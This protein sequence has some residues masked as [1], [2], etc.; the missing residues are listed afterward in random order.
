MPGRRYSDG[1]HQALEAK[2]SVTVERETQTFATVTIQNFFR[3][4]EKL[5]GMTGT[6]ETEAAEFLD[7]Y[8]LDV[9][10]VPTNEPVRRVD[11]DDVIYL[12]KREKYN[13]IIDEIIRMHE[14]GRPVLVGTVSV[15]VSE[16]LS[17][18][19]KRKGINHS[20]LNAKY[21]EQEARIVARAGE[22]G[23]VTI[24][25]NM[26]GRGTDIKLGEGVVTCDRCCYECVEGNCSECPKA[27]NT[28]DKCFDDMPCGLHIIGTE[29]HE[30]RRIDRQLRGRSGRQGDP[31][32][33]RFYL[34]LEDDLMRLFGSDRLAGVISRLG[35]QDGE[36]I[37]HSLIT[38]Q[39]ERAQKRVEANNFA[40]RKHLLEYDDVM[41]KQREV[42]YSKRLMALESEDISPEIREMVDGVV[43]RKL[44]ACAPEGLHPEEWDVTNLVR[45]VETLFRW[46]FD[47]G[48]TSDPRTSSDDLRRK[49]QHAALEAY[50]AKQREIG[51][52]GIK[53]IER[54]LLLYVIDKHW[55]D[56]LYD[57]DGVRAGI[58]LRAYGQKDPLIEYKAEAFELFL[59]ML[60][61]IE[62]E[63]VTLLFQGRWVKQEP[64][65]RVATPRT[66][67]FKPDVTKPEPAPVADPAAVAAPGDRGRQPARTR[68]SQPR[69][70][71]VAGVKVGRNDPCPC[72][73]GKKYKKC[74][75]R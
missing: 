30:S 43:G 64:E 39:I 20:V 22:A 55:R 37:Q 12:T 21:H 28:A 47:L 10:V 34:S 59:K 70:P 51:Y 24:A 72:G 58:G 7:I 9:T 29:R 56:H 6:A 67:A 45:E 3:L 40:I 75:G 33:S 25:T 41:N 1:L 15:E 35:I 4:Y 48:D 13:A 53:S 66:R 68:R 18:L 19:L 60:E 49:I 57:L 73:S 11:Y 65:V 61:S 63:V 23:A 62:E 36:A 50:A 31:G 52:E 54:G 8:K 38:R 42:I 14:M 32:S 44:E 71:L 2:E 74:C 26:A 69:E 17:R 16:I 46:P 27:E 5:A